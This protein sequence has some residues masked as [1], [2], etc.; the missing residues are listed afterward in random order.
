MNN[1]NNQKDSICASSSNE[2][3]LL[4]DE[5]LINGAKNYFISDYGNL[6]IDNELVIP[7]NKMYRNNYGIYKT[8]DI[9]G[10]PIYYHVLVWK[11]FKNDKSKNRVLF[12]KYELDNNGFLQCPIE[13]LYSKTSSGLDNSLLALSNID[14][15]IPVICQHPKYGSYYK[16]K[17]ISIKSHSYENGKE[18]IIDYDEYIFYDHE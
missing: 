14:N 16:N 7:T 11:S 6:K 4:V 2:K 13:N 5:D 10:K 17:W 12:T 15:L 8:I 18:T 1:I 9:C 3:W